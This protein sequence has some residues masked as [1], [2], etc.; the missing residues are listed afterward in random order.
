MS[1]VNARILLWGIE[2]SGKTTTLETIHAKLRDD[3]RGALRR[4]PTRLDPTVHYEALPI[5]LGEVGGVGTQIEL[6]AVPGAPDQAMTRKQLL[7]E[8]DGIVLVLDCSPER[9]RDNAPAIEEL[10]RSLAAYGRRLD[11]FPLVLQYNK[12][13]VADPFAIEDLHRQIGLDQA[14]V[15]ET[16]ATTGHG[17]LPTLTTISKHVVRARRGSSGEIDAQVAAQAAQG[18]AAPGAPVAPLEPAATP[19]IEEIE[20]DAGPEAVPVEP[21]LEAIEIDED[22]GPAST[23]ELLE[24]AIL[25]EGEAE[26]FQTIG[27]IE[28]DLAGDAPEWADDESAA[29]PGQGSLRVVSVGQATVEADGG[30]RLPLVLGDEDGASRSVV[31][32]LRLDALDAGNGSD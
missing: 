7:D 3:L 18:A 26:N 10:T 29:K 31:L 25:A 21:T 1:D 15:F 27:A 14:A 9:I 24:S 17:V 2:G 32:S 4:E 30:V 6:I 19:S 28:V 16:I 8:I 11:A 5:T 12:R 23:A 22:A 13:D 20:I